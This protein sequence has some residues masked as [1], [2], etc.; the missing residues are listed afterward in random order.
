MHFSEAER[1]EYSETNSSD[2]AE[3]ADRSHTKQQEPPSNNTQ[4]K[5]EFISS[6]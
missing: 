5:A 3:N 6:I 1:V 4:K 2:I